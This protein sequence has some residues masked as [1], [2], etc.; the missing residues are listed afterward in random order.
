MTLL[1]PDVLRITI[2]AVVC[3]VLVG[4]GSENTQTDGNESRSSSPSGSNDQNTTPFDDT[5]VAKVKVLADGTILLNDKQVVIDELKTAFAEL[6][7]KNG[8]VWYYREKGAGEP[9]PQAMS[10][11]EAVVDAKLPI[12]L[13][14]NPDFS[15]SVGP[16]GN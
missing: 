9:P 4:C 12:K 15:D 13:S 8:V 14:S 1:K 3:I 11:M 5:N 7:E 10:V 6:K 2:A 16:G